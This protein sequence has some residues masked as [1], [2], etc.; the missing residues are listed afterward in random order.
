M[1]R[2]REKENIGGRKIARAEKGEFF[3]KFYL[4]KIKLT[5]ETLK[6]VQVRGIIIS[7]FKKKFLQKRETSRVFSRN[8]SLWLRISFLPPPLFPLLFFKPG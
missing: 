2:T 6:F 4:E 8:A 7:Y 3:L 1:D 5:L